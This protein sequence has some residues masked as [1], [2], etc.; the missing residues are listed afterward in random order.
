[1]SSPH[2]ILL[3]AVAL[4]ALIGGMPPS[5]AATPSFSKQL[6]QSVPV[7]AGSSVAVQN[8]VGE[9]TVT[10][11]GPAL[12]VNATVVAG[13]SDTATARALADTIRLDVQHDGDRVVVH[14]HYPVDAHDRYQYIPTKPQQRRD[15]GLTI[16]GMHFGSSS[17]DFEYQ[18]RRVQVYQGKHRGL[19]LHVDLQIHLPAGVRATVDNRVGRMHAM[20]V[21]GDLTLKTASGDIDAQGITGTLDGH[22]GSGDLKVEGINGAT[23]LHTGSGDVSLRN[24]RGDVAVATGSGDIDGGKLD[25]T[26]IKLETGSGDIKLDDLAGDLKAESGS[27]DIGLRDLRSVTSARV[28]SGSGDIRIEGD[29][30][31][32]KHFDISSGSGDITLRTAQPPAVHLRANG[33]DIEVDWSGAQ[34]VKTSRRHYNADFGDAGGQGRISTGSGDIRLTH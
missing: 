1:M 15:H 30:S 13:G 5:S 27:G 8:L 31:G 19:P 10:R 21:Q 25:G 7:A 23:N 26:H 6:Q 4:L 2:R 33:S 28:D 20:Q 34:N 32:L 12:E 18:G 16:L 11:G 24:V 29:L 17:S 3:G 22:S 14:V 9:V